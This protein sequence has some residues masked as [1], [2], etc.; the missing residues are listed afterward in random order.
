MRARLKSLRRSLSQ[1]ERPATG[2]GSAHGGR[3]CPERQ[4]SVPASG[5]SGGAAG[6]RASILA[7]FEGGIPQILRD[8]VR[9]QEA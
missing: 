5:S 3:G 2:A 4:G 1:G 9:A 6:S 8:R 7:F